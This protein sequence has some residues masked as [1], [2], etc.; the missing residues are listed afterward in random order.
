MLSLGPDFFFSGS[1]RTKLFNL[2]KV[3]TVFNSGPKSDRAKHSVIH[4]ILSAFLFG[5]RYLLHS[6]GALRRY[7]DDGSIPNLLC[8]I[9]DLY[10]QILRIPAETYKKVEV[11]GEENG[12]HHVRD[13]RQLLQCQILQKGTL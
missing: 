9:L 4:P 5:H 10:D 3:E 11:A 2:Y 6:A 1:Q 13:I 12:F 8:C 7:L